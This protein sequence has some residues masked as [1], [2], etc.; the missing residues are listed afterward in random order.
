MELSQT[1]DRLHHLPDE[2]AEEQL[3]KGQEEAGVIISSSAAM[4]GSMALCANAGCKQ[5]CNQCRKRSCTAS[6]RNKILYTLLY[7]L[8]YSKHGD[9]D[10]ATRVLLHALLVEAKPSSSNL[11]CCRVSLTAG[12]V[13][14][15][16]YGLWNLILQQICIAPFERA[17]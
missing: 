1:A 9:T 14:E 2:E 12:D 15:W 4:H 5:Q 8:L 17:I 16:T 6:Q 11:D 10:I 13:I 7:L 3:D